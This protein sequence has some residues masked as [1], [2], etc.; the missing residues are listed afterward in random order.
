ML[1]KYILIKIT[2]SIVILFTMIFFTAC[3]GG[4][5]DGGTE[6][7]TN[8]DGG[9]GEAIWQFNVG[10][11]TYVNYSSATLSVDQQTIYVGTSTKIRANP[12]R[13]DSLIAINADG[14]LKWSYSLPNGE[15]VRSTPVVHE[16]KIFFIGD[17]RTGEST[18]DYSE[19]FCLD[20]NGQLLWQRRVS[21]NQRMDTTGLSKVVIVDNKVVSIMSYV[22]VFDA[23][24]GEELFRSEVCVGCAAANRFDPDRYINPVVNQNNEVVFFAQGSYQ[25]LDLTDYTLSVTPLESLEELDHAETTPSIDSSGNL[26]FGT[27]YADVVSIDAS[28]TELWRYTLTKANQHEAPNFRSSLAIDEVNGSVYLGIKNNEDS[29]FIALDL[30][31]GELKWEYLVG[32]DVYSSPLI[33]SNGNIYFASETNQLY[34]LKSNGELDWSVGLGGRVS[35]ASPTM[36]NQGM[37]YIGTIGDGQGNGKLIKIKTGS[38]GV[39]QG[40]WSKIHANAQNTGQN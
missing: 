11:K 2:S 26:Y 13:E 16:D 3:S 6:V 38:S 23:N 21:D 19:L 32:G 14:N 22:L 5:D 12:S 35:W 7:V 37:I 24:N 27:E 10:S 29:L 9:V 28:G 36:D 30:I 25:K 39:M 17:R 15:E 33:G 40:P 1:H 31:T 8:P 34:A 20:S 18:K 4:D